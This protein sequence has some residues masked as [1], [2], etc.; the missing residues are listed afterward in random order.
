MNSLF[1]KQK[2]I[3]TETSIACF[4]GAFANF[5]CYDDS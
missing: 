2:N 5:L 1:K 4:W 3:S